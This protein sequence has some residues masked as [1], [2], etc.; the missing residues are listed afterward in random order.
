MS[1]SGIRWKEGAVYGVTAYLVSFV[2][3]AVFFYLDHLG[4]SLERSDASASETVALVT[5][6]FHNGQ[7][8]RSQ[9]SDPN[10]T[11]SNAPL[12]GTLRCLEFF[13]AEQEMLFVPAYH[14]IPPLV[15]LGIGALAAYVVEPADRRGA[16]LSGASLAVG[17]AAAMLAI[18]FVFRLAV[19]FEID[20]GMAAV[21]GLAY[22]MVFGTVGGLIGNEVF[23]TPSPSG[24][25][26][27]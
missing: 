25:A 14:V 6:I 9:L 23:G 2:F 15:L 4:T 1:A 24:T 3:S 20:L 12:C 22:P 8:V 27:S 26:T 21:A 17:Y 13:G 19:G 18:V 11:L 16:A 5:T 10:A 7:F